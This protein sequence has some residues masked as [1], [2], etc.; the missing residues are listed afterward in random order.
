MQ[1]FCPK[2]A[3]GYEIEDELLKD[4]SRKLKCSN[5]GEVFVVD[6]IEV[7]QEENPFEQLATAM[8]NQEDNVSS[9]EIA[10]D[11]PV[12]DSD[13][14]GKDLSES[15]PKE[16]KVQPEEQ[17]APQQEIKEEETP[18]A[19]QKEAKDETQSA[20]QKEAKDEEAS[21]DSESNSSEVANSEEEEIDI[22]DIF[23]R[24]SERTENLINDEKKLPWY[25]KIRFWFKN[26]FGL[27]FGIKWRYVGIGAVVVCLIWLFNN[28]YEMVRRIP[29]ANG[30][31]K[32]LGITAMIPGEGLEFQNISWNLVEQKDGNQLEVRGFVFNQT[33]RSVRIPTIHVEILDKE[34][35]MLQSQ[36]V[37]MDNRELASQDKIAL[38]IDIPQAAPTMK[39]V[40][41]TFIDVD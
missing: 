35:S 27:A 1:I 18:Q 23:E 9:D 33:E 32:A 3:A 41:L 12:V 24:L 39:Y 29:A 30:V 6:K 8:N 31:F 19:E 25:K 11:Q 38:S 28:R 2:C 22:E 4:R 16:E 13:D 5:C 37:V 17:E 7:Q 10:S 15:E 36:N 14:S 26:I 40:Y 21:A 20:E 34:T